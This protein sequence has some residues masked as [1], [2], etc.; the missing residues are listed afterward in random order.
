MF[1]A[2]VLSWIPD[3][4]SRE[5]GFSRS[6]TDKIIESVSDGHLAGSKRFDYERSYAMLLGRFGSALR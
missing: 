6:V 4:A 3:M 2:L 5:R 1:N